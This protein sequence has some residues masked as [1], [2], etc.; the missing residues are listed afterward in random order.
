[1]IHLNAI[2]TRRRILLA[3]IILLQTG[4]VDS[5]VWYTGASEF[6]FAGFE[7][8]A[9]HTG[10]IAIDATT[11]FCAPDPGAC[12]LFPINIARR[13]FIFQLLLSFIF[14]NG[15]LHLSLNFYGIRRLRSIL[16]EETS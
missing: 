13:V 9:R 12:L 8:F 3:A 1:M 10:P 14:G 6:T 16:I 11:L 15:K 5:F 4:I 2:M 7:K